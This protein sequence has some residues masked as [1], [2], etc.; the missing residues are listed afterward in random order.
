[1]NYIKNHKEEQAMPSKDRVISLVTGGGVGLGR[2]AALSLAARGDLV[3]VADRDD[4][5]GEITVRGMTAQGGDAEFVHLD[6]S[7][8]DQ[9]REVIAQVV[10]KHGRLDYAVNNAGIEGQK[11]Q[12]A[13]CSD[14]NWAAVIAVNLSGVFYCMKHEIAAMLRVNKGAIV[15][16]GSTASLRGAPMMPAYTAAK[17]GLVGLTRTA[18]LEYAAQGVRVN[19]IAP[20]SFRTPMS[21]RLYGDNIVETVSNRTPMRRIASAEEIASSIV[22][23]CSDAAAFITG[24]SLPVD[25]GKMAGPVL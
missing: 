15:N 1:L 11:A 23:L 2:A 10:A 22:F 7:N 18:A 14:D 21:E 16:V 12:V 5:Q 20:G 8:P 19:L 4:T 24:A 25:G 17:H 6:V 9:V 13:E 3:V